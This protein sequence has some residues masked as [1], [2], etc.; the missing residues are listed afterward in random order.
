MRLRC[1]PCPF[2]LMIV[3]CAQAIA[4]DGVKIASFAVGGMTFAVQIMRYMGPAIPP[5]SGKHRIVMK[6][7]LQPGNT[8][9]TFSPIEQRANFSMKAYAEE[10]YLT[11]FASTF[12]E[13][14][15]CKWIDN[16]CIPDR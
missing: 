16:I 11:P 12:F 10:H 2:K 8:T 13:V 7:Y 6:L 9:T 3:S 1:E 5:K 15:A 4:R 14:E